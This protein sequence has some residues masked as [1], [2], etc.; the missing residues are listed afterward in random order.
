M[1]SKIALVGPNGV[2]KSTLLKLIA[3]DIEPTEGVMRRSPHVKVG[4]YHQ[5]FMEQL[6]MTQTPLD[7]LLEESGFSFVRYS[8]DIAIACNS[9]K[10]AARAEVLVSQWLAIA[11]IECT[12][13]LKDWRRKEGVNFV[14][15]NISKKTGIRLPHKKRLEMIRK[16]NK[17]PNKA[18][19]EECKQGLIAHTSICSK[20]YF[21]K[22]RFRK[23]EVC[24][25]RSNA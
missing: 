14:G 3:G 9:E 8:D 19:F 16:L 21:N 20:D 15:F 4:R 12:K 5:H 7:F 25:T 23:E 13:V 24:H 11:G 22:M 1:D 17:Q 18:A 6:D 10:D 2:G